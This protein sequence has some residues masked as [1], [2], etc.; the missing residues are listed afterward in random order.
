MLS[1][2][3][4]I[5]IIILILI[6]GCASNTNN[7]DHLYSDEFEFDNLNRMNFKK[8]KNQI[9]RRGKIKT[10]YDYTN[11]KEG[12]IKDFENT[13]YNFSKNKKISDYNMINN[14]IKQ[15]KFNDK[16]K[17][18]DYYDGINL[19]DEDRYQNKEYMG[20]GFFKGK[21]I[22]YEFSNKD[23]Y[24]KDYILFNKKK[25]NEDEALDEIGEFFQKLLNYP[26]LIAGFIYLPFEEQIDKKYEYELKKEME[27]KR[28]KKW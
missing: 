22:K 21:E 14:G 13:N 1:S 10:N 5:V 12:I 7:I 18:N 27:R 17:Y 8:G 25:E 3:N 20:R 11:K 28:I 4:I 15:S 23:K 19:I 2:K 24:N 9:K 26:S 16:K 6:N